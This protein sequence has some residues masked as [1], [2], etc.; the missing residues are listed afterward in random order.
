MHADMLSLTPYCPHSCCC[1]CC[2]HLAGKFTA[3]DAFDDKARLALLAAAARQQLAAVDCL[4]VPTVLEHYLI[5]EIADT[6]AQPTP[7]W[8]LNAKNG[9]F[10]NFVNLLDMC[11]V[12]VPSGLLTVDY[13]TAAAASTAA[14]RTERLKA[15]GGPL[16]VVLPFGVTLLAPAWRDEWLWGVAAA[17]QAAAGL[18]CG[19]SGHGVEPVLVDRQ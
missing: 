17:M 10:T 19:P 16:R 11:G 8:P 2:L 3:T 14:A 9:R 5:Q 6:E 18:G 13:S 15:S 1:C 12:S 7:S 4:L